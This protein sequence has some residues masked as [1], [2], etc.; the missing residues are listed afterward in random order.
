LVES[1]AFSN[2][3]RTLAVGAFDRG[4]GVTVLLDASNG[5]R[6]RELVHPMQVRDGF[7]L[8]SDQTLVTSADD[9]RVRIHPSAAGAG[10]PEHVLLERVLRGLQTIKH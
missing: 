4:R 1:V 9:G 6:Q 2:D 5:L 10:L 7:F 3:G 8:P